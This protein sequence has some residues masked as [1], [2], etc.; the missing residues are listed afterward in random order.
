LSHGWRFGIWFAL[1][2]TQRRQTEQDNV[3]AANE[4][5]SSIG[6]NTMPGKIMTGVM[7]GFAVLISLSVLVRTAGAVPTPFFDTVVSFT[8]GQ[9]SGIVDLHDP[10]SSYTGPSGP[11]AF[12]PAAVTALDRVSLALGGGLHT[13]TPGSIV[14]GFS[15]GRVFLDGPGVDVLLYD[16][17]GGIGEGVIV[18]V[19]QDGATFFHAGSFDVFAPVMQSLGSGITWVTAVDIAPSGLSSAMFLRLTA[20]H[21]HSSLGGYTEAYDLDAAK[22]LYCSPSCEPAPMPEPGTWL[23]LS[24]GL[25][26]LLGYGWRYQRVTL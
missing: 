6:G 23:L 18:D 3:L 15:D 11:G 10:I 14:L 12:D 4:H 22:A 13:T 9:N 17:W 24:T 5:T 26:G 19:S 20:Y 16:S 25:V 7:T 8:P 2:L 1:S 21:L